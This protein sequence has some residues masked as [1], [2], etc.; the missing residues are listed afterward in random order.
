MSASRTKAIEHFAALGLKLKSAREAKGVGLG[1]LSA[2]IRINQV[3][4]QQIEAGELEKLP[5]LTFLRGFVRNYANALGMDETDVLADFRVVTE[6]FNPGPMPLEPPAEV[7]PQR[8]VSFSPT[9]VLL[10]GALIALIVWAGYLIVKVATAPDTA[11][12]AA[13]ESGQAAQPATPTAQADSARS[14]QPAAAPGASAGAGAAAVP[15]SAGAPPNTRPGAPPQ[16][17]NAPPATMPSEPPRNLQLTLRGLERSWIRLS[18]DRRE[19]IDVQLQPAET[20]EWEANQEFR[21][22]VGKSHGVSV[23][24]NG[25]EILLPK[26]QNLLI[27]DLVLNKLTLLKLEN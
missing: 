21:L 13:T 6:L 18:V 9:R 12:P 26:E 19:P 5:A 20:G 24:L 25:E 7:Q 11:Q 15:P 16:G 1:E 17:G 27:P 4:L 23:Y 8:V 3:F 2:N 14:A 22:T 10:I